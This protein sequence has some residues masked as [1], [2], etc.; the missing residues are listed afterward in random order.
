MRLELVHERDQD[1]GYDALTLPGASESSTDY[2]TTGPA[3]KQNGAYS[4]LTVGGPAAN[5]YGTLT[6]APSEGDESS[7]DRR[8]GYERVKQPKD[9]Y[10][11][12]SASLDGSGSGS[13]GV[14]AS[15]SGGTRPRKFDPYLDVVHLNAE[16]QDLGANSLAGVSGLPGRRMTLT[17]GHALST[18]SR[19]PER[20]Y[21]HAAPSV[22]LSQD[23]DGGVNNPYHLASS[24]GPAR[25]TD[26]YSVP[27]KHR[28]GEKIKGT[29]SGASE[30]AYDLARSEHAAAATAATAAAT[31][32]RGAV[33][34]PTYDLAS[35]SAVTTSDS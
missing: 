30:P 27:H 12:V 31:N 16:S 14:S 25:S 32:G 3:S 33:R 23:L 4:T 22:I 19:T 15:G 1:T 28:A 20:A 8:H 7:T 26:V 18:Y 17:D 24:G 10:H 2:S 29:G 34:G 35:T 13:V 21:D 9:T 6:S 5:P 11:D